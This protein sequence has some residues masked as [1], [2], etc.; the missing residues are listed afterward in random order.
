[1]NPKTKKYLVI[2]GA[3]VAVA[4]IVFFI[5]RR[6]KR[7]SRRPTTAELRNIRPLKGATVKR[8]I[9]AR[10]PQPQPQQR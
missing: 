5:V 10:K 1:M 3:V 4:A 8:G 2:G 7:P 6:R 9:G